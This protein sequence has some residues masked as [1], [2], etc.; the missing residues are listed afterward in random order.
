M[1][2]FLDLISSIDLY[3]SPY[4]N[5]YFFDY[6]IL[7]VSFEVAICQFSNFVYLFQGWFVMIP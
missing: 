1:G 4:D 7:I 3:V 6:Y 2:L 5:V